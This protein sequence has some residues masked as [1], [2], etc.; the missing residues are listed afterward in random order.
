MTAIHSFG[1]KV[2]CCL[3]KPQS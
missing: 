2:P 1:Q 3:W